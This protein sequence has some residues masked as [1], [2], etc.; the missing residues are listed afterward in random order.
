VTRQEA[1]GAPCWE[2][3]VRAPIEL[4]AAYVIALTIGDRRLGA[5]RGSIHRKGTPA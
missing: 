1:K 3:G 5:G 4:D 2:I